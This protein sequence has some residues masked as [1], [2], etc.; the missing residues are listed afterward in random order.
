MTRN[1]QI[2][3]LVGA[4]LL[5]FARLVLDVLAEV[6]Q[7][8][9]AIQNTMDIVLIVLLVVAIFRQE[10]SAG[11]TPLAYSRSTIIA[12]LLFGVALGLSVP[13]FVFLL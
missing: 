11:E 8:P 2:A 9:P 3:L 6:S 1:Y 7:R 10:R 4:L 5:A 13:I 12:I